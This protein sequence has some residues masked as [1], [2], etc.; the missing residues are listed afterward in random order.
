[1]KKQHKLSLLAVLVISN[2]TYAEEQLEAINVTAEQ[3]IKQSLG[4]SVISQKDLERDP[5]ENDASEIIAKQPGVTLSTN[6]PGG[7]RGNKRQVDIRAM[8]PLI[9]GKPVKSRNSERYG[10]NFREQYR[11]WFMT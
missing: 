9:D 10:R 5:I 1:M 11:I 6:A 7:A 2:T 3:Q 8:G 4:V